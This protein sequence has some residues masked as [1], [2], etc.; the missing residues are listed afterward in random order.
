MNAHFAPPMMVEPAPANLENS[1]YSGT[2]GFDPVSLSAALL[3]TL[4]I[5]AVLMSIANR[6][7][8]HHHPPRHLVFEMMELPKQL[9]PP[10]AQQQPHPVQKD[11]PST[12][13]IVAPVPQIITPSP[14]PAVV[15]AETPAPQHV[16]AVGPAVPAPPAPPAKVASGGPAEGGDLSSKVLSAKP[17]SY[18]IDSRRLHE[19]GTVVLAVLVA[20]NGK[21]EDISIAHSSGSYRLDRAALSAVRNWRWMPL[22]RDGEAVMVRGMVTIPFVLQA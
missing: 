10:P 6:N 1:E 5:F 14:A 17:P 2:R 3:V 16:N 19:Q 15:V 9:P 12:S 22:M 7:H 8:W 20:T 21:V 13:E 4:G 11:P 18:P